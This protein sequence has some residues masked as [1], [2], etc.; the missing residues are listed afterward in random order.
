MENRCLLVTQRPVANISWMFRPKRSCTLI[1]RCPNTSLYGHITSISK[2]TMN[3]THGKAMVHCDI[4]NEHRCIAL[5][6]GHFVFL[7]LSFWTLQI[8]D[9]RKKKIVIFMW[10]KRTI[11]LHWYFLK[12]NYAKLFVF[13]G[14]GE[15]VGGHLFIF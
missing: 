13:L 10:G 3:I 6:W 5:Y 11:S 2:A 14:G 7:I 15:A 12:L 4:L 8:F 9:L 1:K